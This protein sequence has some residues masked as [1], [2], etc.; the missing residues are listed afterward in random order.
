MCVSFN[1]TVGLVC[2]Y[3]P[4]V[5]TCYHRSSFVVFVVCL[6]VN[7]VFLVV[8]KGFVFW[9]TV[10]VCVYCVY[11]ELSFVI[12]FCIVVNVVCIVVV[13]PCI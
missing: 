3:L 10:S 8:F 2:V 11:C 6:V 9:C 5:P 7:V 1:L 4:L 13:F 12:V